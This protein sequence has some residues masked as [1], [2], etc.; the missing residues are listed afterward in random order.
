MNIS[1]E[2]GG[3]TMKKGYA[4]YLDYIPYDLFYKLGGIL[5]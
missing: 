5:I 4:L 2:R 3:L 1:N